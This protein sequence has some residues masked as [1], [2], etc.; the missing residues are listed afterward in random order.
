MGQR[1]VFA[2]FAAVALIS[3]QKKAAGQTV[4]VVNNEE[5]TASE[6]NDELARENL[7]GAAAT[8]EA[9]NRALQNLINRRLLA[10]QATSDG[11]DKSPEFLKQQRRMTEDLLINMLLSRQLNT[12]Q[13]PSADA[14]KRYEAAHPEVFTNRETWTLDQ[15]VYPL[16][17]DAALTAKIAAAKTLGEIAQALTAANLQFTRSTKEIDSALFPQDAYQQIVKLKPGEPFVVPGPDKAVASVITARK[18]NPLPEDKARQLALQA[19]RREQL[20][21]LIDERVKS[22]KT[23]AKIQYQPGFGPPKS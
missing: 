16:T 19:M 5:I 10:Q 14:I 11:L 8:T 3:C 9:R 4:A 13:V 18:P 17:K 1:I 15:I 2:A 6:L 21:K 20:G 7:S 12:A 23:S 22:L